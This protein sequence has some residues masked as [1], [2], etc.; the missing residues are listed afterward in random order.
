LSA[1]DI[2][3][4]LVY[5]VF[6]VADTVSAASGGTF[7]GG[8]TMG[9]ALN[10]QS[11]NFKMT[12]LTT[13]AFYRS[14]TFVPN[15]STANVTTAYETDA[16]GSGSYL[17]QAGTYIRIGNLV[18]ANFNLRL[19]YSAASYAN[20]AAG[21]QALSI[22]G[23]PFKVKNVSTYFPETSTVYFHFSAQGWE[24]MSL[25]GYASPNNK[26][27]LFRYSTTNGSVGVTT[28]DHPF[29]PTPRAHDSEMQFDITYETDEA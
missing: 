16:F 12:D 5:D 17:T 27:V 26:Y 29:D 1:G 6:N 11:P 25:M 18:H 15:W 7:S 3:E 24:K 22:Y 2:I 10:L 20:G 23:L 21:G 28:I 13:N 14:G 8:V 19:D 4:I 9:G